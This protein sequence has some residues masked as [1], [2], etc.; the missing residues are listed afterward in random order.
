[1][2]Q[3]WGNVSGPLINAASMLFL[4]ILG[5][6]VKRLSTYIDSRDINESLKADMLKTLNVG[7]ASVRAVIAE[8]STDTKQA[9]ADGTLSKEEM[10]EIQAKA[11][12]K[13]KEQVPDLEERLNAHITNGSQYL[14]DVISGEFEKANKVTGVQ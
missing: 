4:L 9:L 6:G 10:A 1:M 8:L 11:V 3:F 2:E 13:V 14:A 12:A 5:I 7:A